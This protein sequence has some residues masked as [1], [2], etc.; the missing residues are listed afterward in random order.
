MTPQG[1]RVYVT[2]TRY[3]LRCVACG[4]LRSMRR[5]SKGSVRRWAKAHRRAS[6]AA[7]RA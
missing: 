4:A 6:C 2:P 7:V 3:T 5:S 1:F